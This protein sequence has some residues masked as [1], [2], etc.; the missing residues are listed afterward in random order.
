MK[1]LLESEAYL[2]HCQPSKRE[3]FD[4]KLR[5]RCLTGSSYVSQHKSKFTGVN[6]F[7]F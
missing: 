5:L 7:L 6:I 4:K 2:E 1:Q 3:L